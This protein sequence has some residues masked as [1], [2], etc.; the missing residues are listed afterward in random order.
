LIWPACFSNGANWNKEPDWTI[1]PGYM[2]S[3]NLTPFL[4]TFEGSVTY[5]LKKGFM[6]THIDLFV[7]WKSDGYRKYHVFVQLIEYDKWIDWD[8]TKL[9]MYYQTYANQL[10]TYTNPIID[11]WLLD[12]DT[13]FMTRLELDFTQRDWRDGVLNITISE[14]IKTNMPRNQ[15]G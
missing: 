7:A 6:S 1:N 12:D 8:K 15:Y 11:T 4:S 5:E 10:S 2:T 9:E 3:A 13:V 14:R